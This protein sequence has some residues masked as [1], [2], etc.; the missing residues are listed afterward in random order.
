MLKTVK[1]KFKY[2]RLYRNVL[3]ASF[4]NKLNIKDLGID[5]TQFENRSVR[6]DSTTK[7]TCR[8]FQTELKT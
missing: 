1:I 4:V 6:A 3:A 5:R 2:F 7:L 8:I